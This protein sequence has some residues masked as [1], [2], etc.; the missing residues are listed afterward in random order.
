MGD[1]LPGRNWVCLL[2]G[3]EKLLMLEANLHTTVRQKK[4]TLSQI[5]ESPKVIPSMLKS[6][7]NNSNHA[8][9]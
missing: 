8:T 3:I 7:V 4:K 5:T 9:Q 6:C 2:R 1:C